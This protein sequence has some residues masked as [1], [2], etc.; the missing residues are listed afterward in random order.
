M[1][2]LVR[3]YFW[4]HSFTPGS[5]FHP[6]SKMNMA[7]LASLGSHCSEEAFSWLMLKPAMISL[8]SSLPFLIALDHSG[9]T[10]IPCS[11]TTQHGKRML[12]LWI[13]LMI[14]F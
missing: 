11:E 7:S 6:A 13:A 12:L 3:S 2:D 9:C 8:T 1:R 5:V 14:S 4:L 10:S